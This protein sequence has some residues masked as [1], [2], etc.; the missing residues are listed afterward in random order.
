MEP[1]R[2]KDQHAVGRGRH[3]PGKTERAQDTGHHLSDRSHRIGK[4]LLRH[5]GH[6]P[7]I[8]ALLGAELPDWL[9]AAND[10]LLP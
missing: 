7:A 8:P 10:A 9:L 2:I 1:R 6:Q 4:L 5:L 3:Q